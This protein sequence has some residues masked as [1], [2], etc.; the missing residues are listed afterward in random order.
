MRDRII[1]TTEGETL[2]IKIMI[3][4]GVGHMKDRIEMEGMVETLVT[5]D[6]GQVQ[7]QLQI[8]I[9]S[10]ALN[11]ENMTISQGIF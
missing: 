1:I 4:I 11:V 8:E 6:Q 2:E 9:G 7:R 10:G 5:V 3:E